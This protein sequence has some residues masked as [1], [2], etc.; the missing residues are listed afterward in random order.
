MSKFQIIKITDTVKLL[1]QDLTCNLTS[2]GT[3]GTLHTFLIDGKVY[4]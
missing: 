2:I 3:F 1:A 4:F